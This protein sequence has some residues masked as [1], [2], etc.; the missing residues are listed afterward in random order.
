MANDNRSLVLTTYGWDSLH[1]HGLI[2]TT[3]RSY[4]K[5]PLDMKIEVHKKFSQLY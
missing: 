3:D 5:E 2:F 1:L 4:G